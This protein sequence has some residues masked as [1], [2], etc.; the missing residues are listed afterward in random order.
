M[1][2]RKEKPTQEAHEHHRFDQDRGPPLWHQALWIG[3]IYFL[4]SFAWIILSDWILLRLVLNEQTLIQVSMFK[5]LGFISVTTILIT[6]LALRL[7]RTIKQTTRLY[8]LLF[9]VNRAIIYERNPT[10]IAQQACRIAAERGGFQLAWVALIDGETSRI[11]PLAAWGRTAFLDH[12]VLD[13]TDDAHMT[14]PLGTALRSG[15]PRICVDVQ[16]ADYMAIWRTRYEAQGLR[17]SAAFPLWIEEKIVGAF[18]CYADQPRTFSPEEISLLTA[19]TDDLAFAIES[20]YRERERR[21]AVDAL[22]RSERRFRTLA[23]YA[24]DAIYRLGLHPHRFTEYISPAITSITGYAPEDYYRDPNLCIDIVH[25]DDRPHFEALLNSQARTDGPLTLRW[26]H[27]NGAIIWIEQHHT[28]I[29]DKQGHFVALEGVARDITARIE[30]QAILERYRLLSENMHDIVLFVRKADRRIIEANAAAEEVYGYSRTRLLQC[31]LDDLRAPSTRPTIGGQLAA[32]ASGGL[33]FETEHQRSDGSTFPVEVSTTSMRYGGESVLLSVIRDLS[34]RR[35]AEA[36]IRLQGEVLAAVA[37][38]IVI[39]DTKGIIQWVNPAFTTLTGYPAEEV[40][41]QNPR[42]FA[43]GHQDRHYYAQLWATIVDGKVW[44][45]ETI[46]RRRDGTIYTE[47]QVITPVQMHGNGITHFV[48]I[49]Q[50]ITERKEAEAALRTAHDA[51]IASYDSTLA[52]WSQALDLR[53]R[54]TEGHSSRVTLLTLQLARVLG[55]NE[56][57][58]EHVRRGAL[59]HDIG[60]I[61]IPDAILHKPGPLTDHEWRIMRRHPEYAYQLLQPI[62]FL[63]PALAIPYCHH[64]HWDGSGY[65]RGLKGDEIPLAARIFTIVDVWDALTSDRPYR[66]ALSHEAAREYIEAQAGSIFDPWI[67]KTFLAMLDQA[68][69]PVMVH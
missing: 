42:I 65:P 11:Y 22:E 24:P 41:G 69:A 43:S 21:N 66:A 18:C 50:D 17:S 19:F 49:K 28:R 39:T 30:A 33:I 46:N 7:T 52:G 2:G 63:R 45:G 53:D 56:D 38:A 62:A 57:E 40:L 44:Q 1:A 59:L 16:T 6:F 55:F 67:V 9:A 68:G 51:L 35:A 20:A 34:Q 26:L 23:E 48:A 13:T 60:K 25:P 54:E 36:Q 27:K 15:E 31:T 10:T 29:Y 5:G 58:L 8:E 37:N 64:E 3:G 47:E 14:S 12:L 4:L 32:A 61:G